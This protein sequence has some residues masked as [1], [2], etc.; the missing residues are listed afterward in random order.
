MSTQIEKEV[1]TMITREQYLL[2]CDD[3]KKQYPEAKF[4]EQTNYYFDNPYFELSDKHHMVR[5]RK[6][7]NGYELTFKMRSID[8]DIE[9]NQ[10]LTG[11]EAKHYLENGSLPHGDIY[12]RVSSLGVNPNELKV[13]T[14]LFTRRLEIQHDDHLFVVDLNRYNGV[15]DYNIEVESNI[16]L[17]HAKEQVKRYCEQYQLTFSEDYYGKSRRAFKLAKK[18]LAR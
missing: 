18:K 11:E 8:G 9:I 6:K 4:F 12:D 3:L 13:M 15:E 17:K 7:E 1:R 5:I 14:D 10:D 2:I 16:S